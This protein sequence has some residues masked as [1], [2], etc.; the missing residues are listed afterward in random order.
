MKSSITNDTAWKNDLSFERDYLAAANATDAEHLVVDDRSD[1]PLP[2][3]LRSSE[4]TGFSGC[5]NVGL[6]AARTDAVLFL[7]NDIVAQQ[8]DWIEPIRELLEPGVFVGA[9]LAL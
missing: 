9:Q 8:R 4:H 7:N 3:A 6:A 2:N 5:N 1:P